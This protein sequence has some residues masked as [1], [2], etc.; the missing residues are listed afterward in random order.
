MH[1]RTRLLHILLTTALGTFAGCADEADLP[2]ENSGLEWA[3]QNLRGHAFQFERGLVYHIDGKDYFLKGPLEDGTRDLPGHEWRKLG[4]GWFVGKHYNSGPFGIPSWWSSDAEDGQL[5]YFVI[6]KIDTW[7]ESKANWY[8]SHGFTH[9]HKFITVDDKT[10]HP[11]KVAWFKHIAVDSFTLDGGPKPWLGHEVTPGVDYEF[12]RTFHFAYPPKEELLYVGC[13]DQGG[14]SPDF[15]AVV[16]AD[17]DD[18]ETY[19]Q[20]IHRADLPGI[21]DEIHHYGTNITQSK[22]L[23]PGLFSGRMHTLNLEDDPRH[24]Y[25]ESYHDD[26]TPDSGYIVPHTVIGM[27]DGGYVV[28]MIGS[29]S[30]TTAPGGMVRLDPDGN[31]LAPFGPPADRDPS[32]TPPT[33]MYD[34]GFNV[35]R[36]KMITT[37]FGLPANV[38]PGITVDGLGTD[39]YVWDLATQQVTQVEDIG[40]GTGALEVRWLNEPGSTIGYTN[41]PGTSEIWMWED[42]DLDGTY[43]FSV[44]IALPDGSIP[45]DI[46]LSADDKYL[47][48]SNWVGNNV[49][50]Y[51]ITDP[52]NPLFID[53]VTIPSS[54]MMRLS[55]DNRRLY[56]TNSLLST[57][58]D[59]EFPAGVTRNTDYG[60]YLVNI[61]HKNGGMELDEDFFVDLDN[62]E[63][64][65]GVGPARP[66]QVFF[67]PGIPKEFGS[68]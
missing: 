51:D 55:P 43:E 10:P 21:G 28:T 53:E 66:H 2:D 57:W 41:A 3:E 14:E 65:N 23:V 15:I 44:A 61:D 58:D 25:V 20:I 24:P 8:A 60:I 12:E 63:K 33:Y 34:V 54:Q 19:S 1:I 4:G 5:L 38:A 42:E 6:A 18:P 45:T 29:N 32:L 40:P 56:V 16:G 47:Y 22:M 67:D 49:M 35:L 62:V 26:L 46:L 37:S 36:G 52:F 48:V 11:S 50:Q 17:P 30:G 59:T 7:S 31:F 68:H 9:Y 27:P 39:I 13:V 64:Q